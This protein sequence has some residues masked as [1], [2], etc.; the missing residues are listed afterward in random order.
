MNFVTCAVVTF[1]EHEL[2]YNIYGASGQLSL[3]N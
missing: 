3:T 2:L 1:R